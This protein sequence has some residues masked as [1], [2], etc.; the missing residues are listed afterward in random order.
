MSAQ[1]Y[2]KISGYLADEATLKGSPKLGLPPGGS[3]AFGYPL[4]E[5]RPPN[6]TTDLGYQE[7]ARWPLRQPRPRT[8]HA[9]SVCRLPPSFPV[10]APGVREA[11]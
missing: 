7:L 3:P 10:D 11:P 1:K 9:G 8:A 6:G 2:G 5:I 4:T